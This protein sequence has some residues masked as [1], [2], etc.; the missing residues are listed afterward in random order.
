[1]NKKMK[2]FKE[3]SK[4]NKEKFY[5]IIQL[6]SRINIITKKWERCKLYITG[7]KVYYKSFKTY[8]EALHWFRDSVYYYHTIVNDF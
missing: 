5:A 6:N 3:N 1:M 4:Q 7:Q 2:K 8:E